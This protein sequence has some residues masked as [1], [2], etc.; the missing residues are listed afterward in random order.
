MNYFTTE[1]I[2]PPVVDRNIPCH[3]NIKIMLEIGCIEISFSNRV[4]RSVHSCKLNEE[5][6]KGY[7]MDLVFYIDDGNSIK[8]GNALSD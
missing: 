5:E 2:L 4:V 7:Y 8:Y 1:Y 3:S 6:I